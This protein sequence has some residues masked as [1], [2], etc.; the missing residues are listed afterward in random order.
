MDP[1]IT[2][3]S[4]IAGAFAIIGGLAAFVRW[5]RPR[6]GSWWTKSHDHAGTGTI[7]STA[8][9]PS[10]SSIS[11]QRAKAKKEL[12]K[13][14]RRTG[15]YAE[16][17]RLFTEAYEEFL[18]LG[19]EKDQANALMNR[20]ILFRM[21]EQ[22]ADSEEDHK[23]ADKLY[24]QER[25]LSGQ[26]DNLKNYGVLYRD[27]DDLEEAIKI[28]QKSL[29]IYKELGTKAKIEALRLQLGSDYGQLGNMK[30]ARR[31]LDPSQ[32]DS[33]EIEHPRCFISYGQPDLEMAKRL[34]SDLKKAGVSCW[35]YG[36]DKTVGERT[37]PEISH[38]M[39]E[40]DKVVVLCSAAALDRDGFKKEIER[41]IDGDAAKLVPISLDNIWKEP[42][43]HIRRGR[44][45]LK[46][47]LEER[48]YADF[49]NLPYADAL[50]ELL[51]G[52][53]RI[54]SSR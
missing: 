36:M 28:H 12:G 43:F 45:N 9:G 49:A 2:L 22:W 52:L 41:Q 47:F 23:N 24:S 25:D 33:E 29:D 53:R 37:W 39:R 13:L 20:G 7:R 48:N 6:A 3:I 8:A 42:G 26:A 14:H 38:Q 44:S 50:A 10:D 27:M 51:V 40:A 31:Y 46:P 32:Q 54:P 4:A 16:A 19:Q 35:L 18:A 11:G 1:Y 17:Q 15:A 21:M 30:M 34:R 5:F